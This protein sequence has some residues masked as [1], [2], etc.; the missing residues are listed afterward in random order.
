M[1]S[2]KFVSLQQIDWSGTTSE[3]LG[4]QNNMASENSISKLR[5]GLVDGA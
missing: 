2:C 5:M 3:L 1:L 4:K